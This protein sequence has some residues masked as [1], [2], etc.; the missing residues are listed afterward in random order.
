MAGT[1][2]HR[3][4]GAVFILLTSLLVVRGVAGHPLL[5]VDAAFPVPSQGLEDIFK[6]H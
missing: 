3:A 2:P 1:S 6:L 5:V 4:T